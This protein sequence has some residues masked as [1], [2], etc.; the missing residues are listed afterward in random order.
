MDLHSDK[1]IFKE[2][3]ALAADHFGY[4]QSHIEKDY[5]VCKILKEIALSEYK[6]KVF[7]KGGTSLSKGLSV[8]MDAID[9][10]VVKTTY[11]QKGDWKPLIFLFTD[12]VPTDNPQ[13]EIERWI[14]NYK[15][16]KKGKRR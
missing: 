1:E 15:S 14:K 12:G 2:L 13:S 16:N 11:E 6:E 5:W 3:I 10:D 9:K 7:F 8:L 4:E